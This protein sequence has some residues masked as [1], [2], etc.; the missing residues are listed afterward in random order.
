M[1]KFLVAIESTIIASK[2]NKPDFGG[3]DQ[4]FNTLTDKQKSTLG[5]LSK[6]FQMYEIT[7]KG[8]AEAIDRG[9]TITTQHKG[10]KDCQKTYSKQV[11]IDRHKCH[12]K[13]K[14]HH[15]AKANFAV[16]QH[17]GADFDE[18]TNEAQVFN[19]PLVMQ[20]GSIIYHTPNSYV[21]DP[22]KPRMR[23]IFLLDEPVTDPIFY[24]ELLRAMMWLF[25]DMV[26]KSCKDLCRLFYGCKGSTP[27]VTDKILPLEVA[28]IWVEQW[29]AAAPQEARRA[30]TNTN[31][32][33]QHIPSQRDDTTPSTEYGI[34]QLRI[35]KSI[36][37]K[38]NQ[39]GSYYHTFNGYSYYLG[40]L[41]GGGELNYNDALA[42]LLGAVKGWPARSWEPELIARKGLEDG[43]TS[44]II[45]SINIP[46]TRLIN[47]AR[48][49]ELAIGSQKVTLI[50]SAKNTGKTYWLSD[51]IRQARA[52]GKR[53]IVLGHRVSLLKEAAQRHGLD[54]YQVF[55]GAGSPAMAKSESLAICA[56]SLGYLNTKEYAKDK[57][58]FILVFD[59][60]EQVLRHLTGDTIKNAGRK[61]VMNK[62]NWLLKNASKVIGLDADMG[63]ISYNFFERMLTAGSIE[64]LVNRFKPAP[65][66]FVDCTQENGK[67][68]WRLAIIESLAAGEKIY[69]PMNGKGATEKLHALLT[70]NFPNKRG[71]IIT[72]DTNNSEQHE[73]IARI[74][75]VVKVY[76]WLIC[77]PSLGTGVSI[78]VEHF[79]KIFLYGIN[80]VTTATDLHQQAGRVRNPKSNEVHCYIDPRKIQKETDP[81]K[82]VQYAIKNATDTGLAL[83]VDN[84]GEVFVE[85]GE[86]Q[87]LHLL[88]D[89]L[90]DKH[91]AWEDLHQSFFDLARI[92][93]NQ[94]IT[95]ANYCEREL[96][97]IGKE[98]SELSK[99]IE[100]GR[101]EEIMAA[102]DVD[103]FEY[104]KL[105]EKQKQG[106][107]E[108]GENHQIA[109]YK[110]KDFWGLAATPELIK[111][112]QKGRS[113]KLAVNYLALTMP[114]YAIGK[115][116]KDF[117]IGEGLDRSLA[118]DF[119]A[120]ARNLKLATNLRFEI[121]TH[122]GIKEVGQFNTKMFNKDTL[123][124]S[125]FHTWAL[126]NKDRI[127]AVLGMK[128]DKY[129]EVEPARLITG[130]LTQMGL[131]TKVRQYKTGV[132]WV[133][134]KTGK[135]KEQRARDY[136]LDGDW[137]E[138]W[139]ELT[140][141][142]YEKEL[143][144]KEGGGEV[145]DISWQF[146]KVA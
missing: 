145:I 24:G 127:S 46:I 93:G 61:S 76:D 45:P 29:K 11:D 88:C 19:H 15:R 74:N 36:I 25:P 133:D 92:E 50:K 56:D 108:E 130:V 86:K 3:L 22:L 64:V 54:F 87:Y 85:P 101:I 98:Y 6:K 113:W 28:K 81:A 69:I 58:E 21:K 47:T 104:D 18:L 119:L 118:K 72:Q 73:L 78:E 38:V 17:I 26:D 66:T 8:I 142:H 135:E 141:A 30:R 2:G 96:K 94:V 122:A 103:S 49:G 60:C 27:T 115:D 35:A 110:I 116:E 102:P 90:A 132:K 136:T 33:A 51:Y 143:K 140:Q 107:L 106:K 12:T 128:I 9:Y 63:E 125:G 82:L 52:Q 79:D 62:I 10:G 34:E 109:R 14:G 1:Q 120:N 68:A 95:A 123:L 42:G 55:K 5:S 126:K 31:A 89:V 16:A 75:E 121:L 84:A 112:D 146:R 13:G 129:I 91:A 131:K 114:G 124:K 53:V 144:Q 77:S 7:A 23:V 40:R 57:A 65:K 71:W 39:V 41:V 97:A 138:R 20:F 59:E 100:A 32:R 67:N 111:D 83:G 4:D 137:L 139:K 37:S 80:G 99:E 134:K 43:E 44:P 117:S 70:L 105:A 48:L